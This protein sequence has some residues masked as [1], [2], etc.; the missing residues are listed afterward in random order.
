MKK[1]NVFGGVEWRVEA[2]ALTHNSINRFEFQEGVC[3]AQR[4]AGEIQQ[5]ILKK[6]KEKKKEDWGQKAAS[7]YPK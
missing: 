2:W 5:E 7:T 6:K 1:L 3:K 4:T